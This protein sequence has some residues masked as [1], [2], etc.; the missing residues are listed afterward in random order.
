MFHGWCGR[1]LIMSCFSPSSCFENV[2]RL[3]NVIWQSNR[4]FLSLSV[5]SGLH[6]VAKPL[7]FPSWKSFLLQSIRNTQCFCFSDVFEGLFLNQTKNPAVCLPLRSFK[8]QGVAELTS[9]L[10][11]KN[12]PDCGFGHSLR[13][14]A[15]CLIGLF[16][17]LDEWWPPL[18]VSLWTSY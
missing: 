10:L 3:L 1:I 8:P 2:Q 9:A 16:S 18:L 11:F 7:D 13:A 14:F 5:K 17:F 4:I 15:I 12:V 6:Y